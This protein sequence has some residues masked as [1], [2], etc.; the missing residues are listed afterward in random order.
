M[1]VTY[2]FG[3]TLIYYLVN[4]DVSTTE[5]VRALMPVT[6]SQYWYFSAYTGVF[7]LIPW[8]NRFIANLSEKESNQCMIVLFAVFSVYTTISKLIGDSFVF[9]GGYCF[10]WL[11]I[12]YVAGAWMKK[13]NIP[14]K[15]SGGKWALIMMVLLLISWGWKT[16]V[17]KGYGNFLFYS[18]LS[19]TV[20]GNAVCLI[21]IFSKLKVNP[22]FNNIIKTLGGAAFGVYIIHLHW[23]LWTN[24]IRDRF[25]WVS[26][27]GSL[28]TPIVLIIATFAVF[29]VC[30]LI[31]LIR[32]YV[33][34]I[35]GITGIINRIQMFI[36]NI[37]NKILSLV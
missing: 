28:A 3:I 15:L 10:A 27:F 35:L 26:A 24:C 36:D 20:I 14:E 25:I 5:L 37:I 1:V 13:N 6:T 29:A 19:P 30:M 8:M 22:K 32:I 18:Y 12:L 21:A 33:F 2:S 9:Y 4:G 31:E 23:I 11:A 34:K 16:I 7:F 17:P